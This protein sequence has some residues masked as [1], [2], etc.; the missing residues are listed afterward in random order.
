MVNVSTTAVTLPLGIES[1]NFLKQEYIPSLPWIMIAVGVGT[2]V[3][4]LAV[5]GFER[6]AHFA[7]VDSPLDAVYLFGWGDHV[8]RS[9]GG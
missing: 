8:A 1:P 6:L 2:V 7:K 5:L 4:L 9:A 3:A